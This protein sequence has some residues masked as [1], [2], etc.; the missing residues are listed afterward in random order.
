MSLQFHKS[1]VC[2]GQAHDSFRESPSTP[3]IPS[4]PRL[5]PAAIG[6]PAVARGLPRLA[7]DESFAPAA[8]AI[9]HLR[10]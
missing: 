9:W 4:G 10:P 2:R 3:E 6:I 5:N 1:L 7:A 8:F